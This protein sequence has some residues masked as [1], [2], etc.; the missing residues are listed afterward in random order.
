MWKTVEAKVGK[1]KMIE[2][3]RRKKI[4]KRKKQWK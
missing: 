2:I 4:Q 3:E 1:T